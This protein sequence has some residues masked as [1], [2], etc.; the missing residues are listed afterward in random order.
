MT[1]IFIR[2]M[3]FMAILIF[4]SGLAAQH[5]LLSDQ[6]SPKQLKRLIAIDTIVIISMV[7][8]FSMGLLLW[9]GVGKLEASYSKNWI[10]HTKITLFV[11]MMFLSSYTTRFLRGQQHTSSQ[12]IQIPASIPRVINIELTILIFLP[13]LAVLMSHG[14]GYIGS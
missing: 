1:E 9:F 8:L 13:L 14:Y 6:I 11:V 4:T 3:H 12:I 7:L 2:Y 5:L 10:F